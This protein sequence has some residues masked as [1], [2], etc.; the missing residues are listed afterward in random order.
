M[1]GKSHPVQVKEPYGNLKWLLVDL[2]PAT[3]SVLEC[4]LCL[5]CPRVHMAV[6]RER[7][8]ESIDSF[9]ISPRKHYS[10]H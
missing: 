10:T 1:Q 8:K 9:L 6:C 4:T 2:H 7:K 3:R 5:E